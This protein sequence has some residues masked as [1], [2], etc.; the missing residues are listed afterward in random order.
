MRKK[1]RELVASAKRDGWKGPPFDPHLLASLQG[2]RVR[3]VH[4]EIG[5]EARVFGNSTGVFIEYRED[6][7]LPERLRFSI[8]HE[9]AHT[10][11]PDCYQ[12]IRHLGEESSSEVDRDFERLCDIGASEMLFPLSEFSED[13]GKTN[14]HLD[15]VCD[16]K[17]RYAA[18][19]DATVKRCMDLTHHPRA[20]V[21][22]HQPAGGEAQSRTL[23]VKYYWKSSSFKPFIKPGSKFPSDSVLNAVSL[24][25]DTSAKP[26]PPNREIWSSNGARLDLRVQGIPLPTVPQKPNYPKMMALVFPN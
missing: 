18:S 4:H 3:K 7:A 1:C 25:G 23:E 15:D 22:F 17:L 19:I 5:G 12:Q 13:L 2:I 24:G 16:L 11:F 26:P 9:I 20:A 14:V 8:F 6:L 21:F 10:L